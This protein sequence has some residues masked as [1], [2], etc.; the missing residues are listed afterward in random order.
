MERLD[1]LK[2]AYEL[3]GEDTSD[4]DDLKRKDREKVFDLVKEFAEANNCQMDT[5]PTSDGLVES[6]DLPCGEICFLLDDD[7]YHKKM[8]GFY[9]EDDEYEKRLLACIL[10]EYKPENL[11]DDGAFG[12]CSNCGYELN[13]ELTDEYE[14]EFC[15]KCGQRL[16]GT[17]ANEY[18]V[19]QLVYGVEFDEGEPYMVGKFIFLARCNN[20]VICTPKWEG[21][22]GDIDEQLME[23]HK[24]FLED[25]T[26]N[27]C[28]CASE[29]I[30]S[31]KEEAEKCLA[32]LEQM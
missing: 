31:T 5:E 18:T 26:E 20:Y 8:W 1:L 25:T 7:G 14:V 22:T 13:S 23:M 4:L 11:I 17:A 28:L 9:H 6:A 16:V 27:V 30:F 10:S 32:E 24:E 3:F 12:K 19:G 2:Q 29:H 21:F 15:P